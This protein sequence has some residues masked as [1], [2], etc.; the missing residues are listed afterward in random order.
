MLQTPSPAWRLFVRA[1]PADPSFLIFRMAASFDAAIL[2][3]RLRE[4]LV[5]AANL[6]FSVK[7]GACGA[8][9]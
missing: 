2:S 6:D 5:L 9:T 4:P 3:S 7:K 1:G 8:R